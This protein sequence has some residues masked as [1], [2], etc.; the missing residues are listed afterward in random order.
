MLYHTGKSVTSYKNVIPHNHIGQPLL[1]FGKLSHPADKFI[2]NFHFRITKILAYHSSLHNHHKASTV[3]N[4]RKYIWSIYLK[5]YLP[6][7][8]LK[9]QSHLEQNYKCTK[10]SDLWTIKYMPTEVKMINL[11]TMI[12]HTPFDPKQ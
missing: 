12:V 4:I 6:N 5:N 1:H 7:S 10:N 9:T 11:K 3:C 8:T 2:I